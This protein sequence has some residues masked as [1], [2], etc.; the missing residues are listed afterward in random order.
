MYRSFD[1][2]VF[3]PP[4]SIVAGVVAS[5]ALEDELELPDPGSF[6][7]FRDAPSAGSGPAAVDPDGGDVDSDAVAAPWDVD[8]TSGFR[9]EAERIDAWARRVLA[10]NRFGG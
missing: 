8:E 6:G 5:A 1:E 9:S 3:L 4:E 10:A 7:S 2:E